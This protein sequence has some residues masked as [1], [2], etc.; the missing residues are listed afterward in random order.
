MSI[1]QNI[2]D[3][4][5]LA[6]DCLFDELRPEEDL[7]VDFAGESSEFL[8]FNGGKVRQVGQVLQAGVQLKYFRDGRTLSTAFETSGTA[9]VDADRA[10]QALS[11]VRREA[12]LLPEDPYQTLPV[13]QESSREVFEGRLPEP[14]RLIEEI[15]GPGEVITAAGADFV[16]LHA[17]GLVCRGAANRAGARHWFAT[18]TFALDYSA[19]LTNGKAL[20]SGYAGR[21][22]EPRE[23][24]HRLASAGARLAALAR[25]EKVIP[26]GAYR[27]FI[28]PE[29]VNE[30]V[31][32]FS[33]NGLGERGLRE[34]ESSY[35]A[36]REGR[37]HL[38]PDFN[39]VQDFSLGVEPRFNAL[40]EMA[41]GK[42]VL[43]EGG[44][45]VNTLVSA[46]SARQY[47]VASNA[48]PLGEEVRSPAI[49][50]GTLDETQALQLLGTGLY[51]SNLHY[52]NWSDNDSGRITGMTRF[53]CFW[54]EDGRIVSPIKDMR[55]D[56]SIYHL[57]G[58]KLLGLTRQRSL[59][60]E[61]GSYFQRALGGA[62]LPG[63]LVKDFTFTL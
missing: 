44:K 59:I 36:L 28:A 5:H 2:E 46:R 27:V 53:A 13:S 40:G 35:L 23:Y 15:L 16:G 1:V 50:A 49:A 52:L 39:L 9:A 63:L 22:W 38:S 60:P 10:A 47:G 24:A 7:A 41:P 11:R 14:E 55:F 12:A 26:P 45:L 31:G 25:P 51:L 32:F 3:R 54:V 17:Q 58:D 4:F 18:E 6:C 56:E 20:K 33:W 37:K 62:L 61:T 30:F 43:I 42:L 48:A 34:G 21:E 57:F 8:R 19:F 29:A